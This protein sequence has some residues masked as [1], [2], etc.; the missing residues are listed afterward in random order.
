[1]IDMKKFENPEN[2]DRG[3]PFWSWNTKL[4]KAKLMRQIEVFKDMGFGGYHIHPRVGLDTKYLSEEYMEC[5]K[6][7]VEKGK[8]LGLYT[9]LYDEDRWPSGYG[10]GKV[11]MKPEYRATH[12][13]FTTV[14]YE[15][16]Q[17][18][19]IP[20]YQANFAIGVRTDAGKLLATYDVVL[21]SKGKMIKYKKIEKHMQAEGTKWY[22]Y[23]E[24]NPVHSWYNHGAY[25]D[26]LNKE[27]IDCFLE[28]IYAAYYREVGNEFGKF[29]PAIFT[30]EPHMTYKTNLE[31]PFDKNDIFLP[32]TL[33]IEEEA[34]ENYGIHLLED[35]PKLFWE[36]GDDLSFRYGYHCV[37]ADLFENAFAKNIGQWCKEHKIDFTGHYLYEEN[38]FM[39][40]RSNGDLMRMYRHM[41]VPGMDLLL[42][43]VALTTGKQIQS[44]VHQY[45]KKGAMAEAYGVTNWAFDFREYKFQSDWQAALGVTLRVPHLAAMSLRGESKRDFPASIFYQAPWYKEF[46]NLENHFARTSYALKQGEPKVRIAMIHPLESYWIAYG[47]EAQTAKV[48]K[49][50]NET[51]LTLTEW[52]LKNSLD[53]DYLDEALLPELFEEKHL[54]FGE[55]QYDVVLV[56][57]LSTIRNSTVEI[58]NTLF[59]AGKEVIYIEKKPTRINGKRCDK[60]KALQ[61]KC[62]SN[63]KEEVLKSLEQ[64]RE[65]EIR[66]ANGSKNENYIYQMKVLGDDKILFI[67]PVEKREKDTVTAIALQVEV[68]GNY[69]VEIWDTMSG[70]KSAAVYTVKEEKTIIESSLYRND[71]LLLYMKKME[72][73]EEVKEVRG[74]ELCALKQCTE[75]LA[76]WQ[77]PELIEYALEEPNVALLDQAEFSIDRCAYEGK[78][79]ILRIDTLLRNRFGYR[80]R[81]SS[82]AQPYSYEEKDEE[83]ALTLRYMVNSE[84]DMTEEVL[85]AIE[86]RECVSVKWNGTNC[87]GDDE[88]WYIDEDIRK[89]KLG[90]LQKGQN[91]LEITLPYRE[92]TNLEAVYLLGDFSVDVVGDD[93]VLRSR[94]KHIKFG[95]VVGQGLDFYGGNIRYLFEVPVV[96]G[97]LKISVPGYRGSCI[98]VSVDTK[99][100]GAIIIAPYE[101]YIGDLAN[102]THTVEIVLYGNRYNTLSHLHDTNKAHE[103]MSFPRFWRTQGDE[104]SYEYQLR[105][106]GIMGEVEI[107]C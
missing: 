32:W 42:D 40:N 50:Q 20:D 33:S 73:V 85:L 31:S 16:S 10:G 81:N 49:K 13:L 102:G 87:T 69:H 79:E 70:Q 101:C 64:Y 60:T 100:K 52:L 63:D 98:G 41:D 82:M 55:M 78:E 88:G 86:D 45:G 1:M 46:K 14:S 26:V 23:I 59:E 7:C 80:A 99:E 5:V 96:N 107:Y 37:L 83:H 9:Y 29:V 15:E 71:S 17:I 67:A 56:P 61:G 74:T 22:A 105:A 62:I 25:V 76:R 44:I 21:D 95:N 38:L 18:D 54:A 106:M 89:M 91:I 34:K 3:A 48:R 93:F 35:L 2:Q 104:W 84:I 103:E 36:N 11:T 94:Q 90:V 30:D 68:L 8:S 92:K 97:A 72:D 12:L 39:Q 6:L 24:E 65:V 43:E 27:A 58:L 53:F 47:T 75:N 57:P 66:N 28:E 4:D 51:F 77:C 19:N